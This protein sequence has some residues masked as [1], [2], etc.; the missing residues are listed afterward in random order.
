MLI[1]NVINYNV[2]LY[3][4]LFYGYFVMLCISFCVIWYVNG[5][6]Y[7]NLVIK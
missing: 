1:E 3:K 7:N 2:I 5:N 6:F 4:V